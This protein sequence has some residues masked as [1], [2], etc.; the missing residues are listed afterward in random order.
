V[1]C[2]DGV[3]YALD[4]HY[5]DCSSSACSLIAL[6]LDART[7]GGMSVL[8]MS[9][10]VVGETRIRQKARNACGPSEW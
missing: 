4:L 5:D 6:S 10:D 2:A 7:N 3:K 8:M 9:V 1:H